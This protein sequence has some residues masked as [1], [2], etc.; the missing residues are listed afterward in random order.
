[1]PV[2]PSSLPAGIEGHTVVE[3]GALSDHRQ[4][5][6]AAKRSAGGVQADHGHTAAGQC[7][8]GVEGP[9]ESPGQPSRQPI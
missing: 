8:G 1:M 9:N 5:C 6:T 7:T 2:S 4:A 3:K